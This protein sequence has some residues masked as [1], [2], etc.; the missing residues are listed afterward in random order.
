MFSDVYSYV[1]VRAKF[2][3]MLEEVNSTSKNL[4]YSDH[5]L[6]ITGTNNFQSTEINSLKDDI[7]KLK[8][9]KTQNIP[10]CFWVQLSCNMT[11]LNWIKKLPS[12]IRRM[13]NCVT[14]T[15]RRNVKPPPLHILPRNLF[16]SH[17]LQLSKR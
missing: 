9:K 16:T 1:R 3:K 10:T 7:E 11:T 14:S 5:L 13:K 17:G 6:V 8:K 2:D 4:T 15:G 12:L